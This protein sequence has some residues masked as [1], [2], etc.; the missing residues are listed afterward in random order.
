MLLAVVSCAVAVSASRLIK[1]PASL[2]PNSFRRSL[3]RSTICAQ[4]LWLCYI[5]VEGGTSGGCQPEGPPLGAWGLRPPA[6]DKSRMTTPWRKQS[7]VDEQDCLHRVRYS[8]LSTQVARL[9]SLPQC[10]DD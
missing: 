10:R 8:S 7:L 9:K 2:T 4:S 1:K 3:H 5:L 6:N